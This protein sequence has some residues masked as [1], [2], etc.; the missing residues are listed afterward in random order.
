MKSHRGGGS[1]DEGSLRRGCFLSFL[2]QLVL[3][4]AAPTL[5]QAVEAGQG[6]GSVRETTVIAVAAVAK[7]FVGDL[8]EE[9]EESIDT[10][11][12]PPV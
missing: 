2:S 1:G 8:I 3:D 4:R 10:A 9:G 12:E 6:N 11:I 5:T 7:M